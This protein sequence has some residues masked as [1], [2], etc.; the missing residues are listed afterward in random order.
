M[1]QKGQLGFAH[2][3]LTAVLTSVTHVPTK[4]HADGCGLCW[5]HINVRIKLPVGTIF[6]WLMLPS[7]AMFMYGSLLVPR[8]TSVSVVIWQPVLCC[9]PWPCH[10]WRSCKC[11]WPMLLLEA[12]VIFRSLL[13]PRAMSGFKTLLH[14]RSVLRPKLPPKVMQ[15]SIRGLWWLLKPCWYPWMSCHKEPYWSEWPTLSPTAILIFMIQA[16]S[17]VLVWYYSRK[18]PCSW[19]VLSPETM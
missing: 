15:M 16:V 10:H 9:C 4:G 19:S 12:I 11:P 13:H 3:P 5:S 8:A 2:W 6:Q 18:G 17:K 14:L 7:E 1:W